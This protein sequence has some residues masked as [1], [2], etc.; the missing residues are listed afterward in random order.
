[1]T[2]RKPERFFL[3]VAAVLLLGIISLQA[4]S[5]DKFIT[6]DQGFLVRVLKNSVFG[7]GERFVF[8]VKY[9]FIKGGEAGIELM[10]NMVT[11]RQA[12]CLHIHT[13]AKSSTTFS[14]FFKVDDQINAYMDARGLFAWYFEKRLNEGNYHDIKVVDYDQRLGKAY[15]TDDGVP[16]DTGNIL[17]FVQDAISALYYYRL[18]PLEVGKTVYI[19]I[20]DIKKLYALK[21]DVLGKETVKVPAGT[22]NCLKVEPKLESAGI[23]KGE[24]RIHLWLTDDERYLPVLMQTKVLIGSITAELK[25][26]T[27]GAPIEQS[28][29]LAQDTTANV[30]T[31]AP[32]DSCAPLA[33]PK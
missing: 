32:A 16:K 31:T 21:V 10:P 23:F 22:F 7:P 18:Q 13:W 9:G 8:D 12:P 27:P 4:A 20:Y 15:T 11:W 25:S 3:I 26:Y 33:D 29:L 24:G 2:P 1:M 19:D 5:Q 14:K 28:L 17:L 30:N 6:D